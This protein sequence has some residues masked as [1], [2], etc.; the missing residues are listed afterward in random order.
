[1]KLVS[2]ERDLR[3]VSTAHRAMS[4]QI[5]LCFFKRLLPIAGKDSGYYLPHVTTASQPVQ[6]RLSTMPACPPPAEIGYS[7]TW[8]SAIHRDQYA[9]VQ[10]SVEYQPGCSLFYL[11]EQYDLSSLPAQDSYSGQK[12]WLDPDFAPVNVS[13]SQNPST[14]TNCMPEY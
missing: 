7:S 5:M 4:I 3:R 8:F 6:H 11:A 9:A 13:V 12:E 14:K 1:M 10:G 2:Q